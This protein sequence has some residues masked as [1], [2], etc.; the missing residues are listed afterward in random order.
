MAIVPVRD[1]GKY[2]VVTD[3]DPFNLPIGAWSF[4][5]NARFFDGQVTRGPVFRHAA[6][7]HSR[8]PRFIR[9]FDAGT[10]TDT[11]LVGFLR[12]AT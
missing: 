4:G 11:V 9:A 3:V 2:G 1:L 12:T 5:V 10:G 8:D 6:T 7:A